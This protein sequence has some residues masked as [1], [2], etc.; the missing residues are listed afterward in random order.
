[1]TEEKDHTEK[2][3][4]FC[5]YITVLWKHENAPRLSK[6]HPA[7]CDICYTAPIFVSI[8]EFTQWVNEHYTEIPENRI[9]RAWNS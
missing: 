6:Y 2:K 9:R 4:P 8:E 7:V 3:C 1:M 5:E